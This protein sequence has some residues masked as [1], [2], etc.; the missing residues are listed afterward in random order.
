MDDPQPADIT[1]SSTPVEQ[2][3]SQL[4]AHPTWL[5]FLVT[6]ILA[7]CVVGVSA[8]NF[9]DTFQISRELQ[10]VAPDNERRQPEVRAAQAVAN[11]LNACLVVG[12]AGAVCGAGGSAVGI[13]TGL[14]SIS[15]WKVVPTWTLLGT[16]WGLIVGF[17]GYELG[18]WFDGLQSGHLSTSAADVRNM[19]RTI[20]THGTFWAG[21]GLVVGLAISGRQVRTFAKCALA[22][23][24][25]GLIAALIYPIGA[26]LFFKMNRSETAVPEGLAN[27]FFWGLLGAVLIFTVVGRTAVGGSS[28]QALQPSST[29]LTAKRSA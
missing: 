29:P 19:Y 8:H 12:I 10:D 24:V 5:P 2:P 25:A 3:A 15:W 11:V 22:G 21:I 17:A 26:G 14:Q 20:I 23:I 7:G 13:L 4:P 27:Q 9:R 28:R 6:G 18:L 16:V 1:P